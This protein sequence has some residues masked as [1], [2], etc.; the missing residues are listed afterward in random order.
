M[1][2]S[3]SS[4]SD[5][6]LYDPDPS[7]LS[8]DFTPEVTLPLRLSNSRLSRPSG[9]APRPLPRPRPIPR[10]RPRPRSPSNL[11]AGRSPSRN[12]PPPC[13]K[14]P[15]CLNSPG[16]LNPSPSGRFRL[17]LRSSRSENFTLLSGP[18]RPALLNV[19]VFSAILLLTSVLTAFFPAGPLTVFTPPFALFSFSVS[20]FA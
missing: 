10:P 17:L 18:P 15:P 2:S 12:S 11:G 5:P 14:S 13:L 16:C 9:P 3:T 19:S 1:F 8:T 7:R 4:L 20:T 6:Q